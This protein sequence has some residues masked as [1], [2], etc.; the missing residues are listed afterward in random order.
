VDRITL[1]TFHDFA[2]RSGVSNCAI[3]PCPPMRR[4]LCDIMFGLNLTG[5]SKYGN[6]LVGRNFVESCFGFLATKWIAAHIKVVEV[7]N[8]DVER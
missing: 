2:S 4:M 7:A 5:K 3:F 6:G 8:N 1:V